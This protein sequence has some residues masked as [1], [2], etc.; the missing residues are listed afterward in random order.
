MK[1]VFLLLEFFLILF[2]VLSFAYAQNLLPNDYTIQFRQDVLTSHNVYRARHKVAP[3]QLN[4]KLNQLAQQEAERSL[5]LK[6]FDFQP[7][8]VY[9][10]EMLG[11]SNAQGWS[12][13]SKSYSGKN[14]I[15]FLKIELNS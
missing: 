1:P 4:D 6:H 8:L 9:N 2:N 7:N 12:T 10:G 15:Y 13:F 11:R 3:V 14:F 5:R